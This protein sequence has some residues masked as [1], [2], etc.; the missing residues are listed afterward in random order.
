MSGSGEYLGYKA[1]LSVDMS[2]VKESMTKETSFGENKKVFTSGGADMP[3]PIGLKLLPISRAFD[4]S[5]YEALE[6]KCN[7]LAQRKS[8]VL[9]LFTKYP[10][11]KNAK[12]PE[13]IIKYS[14]IF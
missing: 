11:L 9:Q 2:K 8:N 13:G 14:K 1:S 4:A 5:L 3:E 10:G 12:T 7:N 6:Y